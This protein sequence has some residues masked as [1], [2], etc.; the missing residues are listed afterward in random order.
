M[1]RIGRWELRPV[2]REVE[3]NLKASRIQIEGTREKVLGLEG[4]NWG[5]VQ[6]GK[7]WYEEE[8]SKK[9]KKTFTMLSH[10]KT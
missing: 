7:K 2:V 8:G 3:I 5:G 1:T 9:N 10:T 4:R 6:T